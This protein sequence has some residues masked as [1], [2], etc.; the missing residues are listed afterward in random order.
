M[1]M[2]NMKKLLNIKYVGKAYTKYS[3]WHELL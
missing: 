1:L 2:K 3:I